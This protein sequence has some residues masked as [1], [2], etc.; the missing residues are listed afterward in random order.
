MSENGKGHK[1]RPLSVD[2]KTFSDNWERAFSTPHEICEY[3]GLPKPVTMESIRKEITELSN[4]VK[5]ANEPPQEY[6]QSVQSGM[7]WELYP[8]L[9]GK[10]EFDSCEWARLNVHR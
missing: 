7:F 1:Q 2:Q 5:H 10:W 3:S 6:L 9:S 4:K 8:Q